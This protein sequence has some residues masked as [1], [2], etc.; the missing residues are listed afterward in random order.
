[1]ESII[2]R[3]INIKFKKF[4][5]YDIEKL[6]GQLSDFYLCFGI[7]SAFKIIK[8]LI[9]HLLIRNYHYKIYKEKG[10]SPK[11][12][13]IYNHLNKRKDLLD[14]FLKVSKC[15]DST[16]K[17]VLLLSHSIMI[18]NINIITDLNLIIK[19][20]NQLKQTK[21]RI[22]EKIDIITYLYKCYELKRNLDKFYQQT[23]ALVVVNYDSFFLDNFCVQYF[24][25]KNIKTATLQHGIIVTKR[26]GLERNI[27]FC[28]S[29]FKNSIADYFLVWNLF[30]KNQA[31]ISGIKKDKIIIAGPIKCINIKKIPINKQEKRIIG[32]LL[33]GKFTEENNQAMIR[34]ANQFCSFYNYKYILRYHPAYQGNEYESEINH[35]YYL[36]NSLNSLY[37][38]ANQVDYILIGNSTAYI[39]LLYM[40]V[41][42]IHFKCNP[43]SD[44]YKDL[45]IPS[46]NNANELYNLIA[47]RQYLNETIKKNLLSV[48]DIESAYKKFFNNFTNNR[49]VV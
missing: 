9:I 7:P 3:I 20:F 23:P 14:S 44:K 30:T 18:P 49:N 46:F 33:D 45:C 10:S 32:I 26:E 6:F 28:G 4:D 29:E 1:M 11:I 8:T 47:S 16:Q 24:Q 41:K 31:I 35:T 43:I 17:C 15:V 22:K 12:I 39:E 48:I 38:F 34:I 2:N 13:F 36:G 21:L 42:V 40:N 25:K 19:W 5:T 27:D 37:D